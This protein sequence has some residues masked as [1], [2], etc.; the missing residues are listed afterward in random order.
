MSKIALFAAL[1]TLPAIAAAQPGMAELLEL[2]RSMVQVSVDLGNGRSGSGTGVVLSPQEVITNCHVL[3]NANGV[4]VAKYGD[5]HRPV[6]LKADWKHDLCLLRFEGL[7][8]PPVKL[9]D[10]ASLQYQQEVFAISYPNDTNVPQPSYG[11]I[12]AIYPYDG[13]VIVRSSAAFSLGSSGGAMFDQAFN[14]IGITTF[15]SPGKN[16][17]FYSMP[18]EW[19]HRLREA[20]DTLSLKTEEIPFWALPEAERPDFMRV[21]IPYQNREWDTLEKLAAQWL[22][23]EPANADALHFLAQAEQGLGKTAQAVEHLKQAVNINPRHLD[24]QVTLAMLAIAAG[25]RPGA[26]RIRDEVRTLDEEAAD[27]L[28]RNIEAMQPNASG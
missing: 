9:R 7:P 22:A 12:K 15:K 24:A 14:L 11:S 8:F 17:Y 16:A 5:A 6:A 25:D 10:S 27:N 26:E 21:V 4:N 2:N 18:V 28:S 23:R 20:P 13:S 3:A 19:I 1:L